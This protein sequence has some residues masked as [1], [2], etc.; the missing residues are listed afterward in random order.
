MSKRDNVAFDLSELELMVTFP[1]EGFGKTV[2]GNELIFS[3][4]EKSGVN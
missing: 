4:P 2:R 3:I 1:F